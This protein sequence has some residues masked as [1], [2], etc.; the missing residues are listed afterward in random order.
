MKSHARRG[1]LIRYDLHHIEI[2][3]ASSGDSVDLAKAERGKQ[4][5]GIKTYDEKMVDGVLPQVPPQRPASR[6]N[7]PGVIGT[8][9]M[10]VTGE[11]LYN[12]SSKEEH[13]LS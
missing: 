4:G 6:G 12:F 8:P 9:L 11:R 1:D 2:P 10:L 7:K 3:V 13:C 5:V